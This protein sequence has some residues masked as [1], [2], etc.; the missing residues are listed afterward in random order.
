VVGVDN[1]AEASH[2]WPPLTTVHQPLGDA[3]AMAVEEIDRLIGKARQ[4]RPSR[5]AAP[6]MTL[7]K[8]ELIV[9]ESARLVVPA[10]LATVNAQPAAAARD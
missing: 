9:R 4:P 6:E 3:G 2:F 8:P 1:M 7:L 5:Q 10:G